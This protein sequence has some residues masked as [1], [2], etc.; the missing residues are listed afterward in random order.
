MFG[1]KLY[2]GRE[3]SLKA[4]ST[5]ELINSY[6]SDQSNCPHILRG[7]KCYVA[8]TKL[9]LN[10]A[11]WSAWEAIYSHMEE[12]VMQAHENEER[13][14]TSQ[15]EVYKISWTG[16]TV[17]LCGIYSFST[18]GVSI[19]FPHAGNIRAY[20]CTNELDSLLHNTLSYAYYFSQ[21][22]NRI[23]IQE[24]IDRK[25]TQWNMLYKFRSKFFDCKEVP[26]NNFLLRG[27]QAAEDEIGDEWIEL[28]F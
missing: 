25:N 20:N 18:T 27:Y 28:D 16:L 23:R 5:I 4:D 3:I 26:D 9:W 1:G 15:D 21:G 22:S 6:V 19:P 13:E 7:E 17:Y 11:D 10:F 24:K 2:P 12:Y 8:S 14:L